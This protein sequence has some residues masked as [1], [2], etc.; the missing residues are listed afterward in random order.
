MRRRRE[1]CRLV[2]WLWLESWKDDSPILSLRASQLTNDQNCDKSAEYVTLVTGHSHTK[3]MSLFHA[4]VSISYKIER[5]LKPLSCRHHVHYYMV[6]TPPTASSHLRDTS[7]IND[8]SC[9]NITPPSFIV[10][11][12][13]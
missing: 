12:S 7:T 11:W 9:S 4:E 8:S 6:G 1:N 10:R 2:W 5:L 3:E 13:A